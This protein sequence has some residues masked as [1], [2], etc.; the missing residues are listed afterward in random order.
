MVAA[1]VPMRCHAASTPSTRLANERRQFR[2]GIDQHRDRAYAKHGHEGCASA[3]L[4]M[5][6]DDSKLSAWFVMDHDSA[7]EDARN[8]T[9]GRPE[10]HETWVASPKL[11]H[12]PM[13]VSRRSPA[14][15]AALSSR[16]VPFHARN[17][18]VYVNFRVHGLNRAAAKSI[19]EKNFGVKNAY[20]GGT[21]E[22]YFADLLRTPFVV[23][24]RGSKIDCHRHWEALALGAAPI[25]LD[26]PL[27]RELFYGLPALL[28]ESWDALT[29]ELLR[30]HQKILKAVETHGGGFDWA[31]LSIERWRTEVAESRPFAPSCGDDGRWRHAGHAGHDCAW[32]GASPAWRCKV[33]GEDDSVAAA[34]CSSACED[35]CRASLRADQACQVR[36]LRC[37]GRIEL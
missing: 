15:A 25:V 5:L 26:S 31:R 24:P 13:G 20:Y 22:T 32:V 9:K 11:R 8:S 16:K 36:A 35:T 3:L 34:V 2:D 23:S 33:R 14:F 7:I 28:L 30:A 29:P 37:A 19:A 18:S 21:D 4:A 1:T 17:G 12:V 27:T 10:L 6:A